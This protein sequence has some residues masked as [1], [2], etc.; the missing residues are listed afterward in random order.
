[1]FVQ[2][3]SSRTSNENVN[4]AH[5]GEAA[6]VVGHHR[7]V[8]AVQFLDDLKTLVELSEDVHHWAGEQSMLRRLLELHEEGRVDK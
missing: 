5:L 3:V 6:V 2:H 7:R 4:N 8:W 1:M